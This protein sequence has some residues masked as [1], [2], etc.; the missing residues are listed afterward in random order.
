MTGF[1]SSIT[2][3]ATQLYHILFGAQYAG[4]NQSVER[5]TLYLK[6]IEKSTSDILQQHSCSGHQI[7][8][9]GVKRVDVIIGISTYINQLA[10][11]GFG[12]LTVLNR[13]NTP[14]LGSRNL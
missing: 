3:T 2:I 5:D 12:I 10:L 6:T 11:T 13:R 7:R 1:F 8:N 9:A 4:N 14:T